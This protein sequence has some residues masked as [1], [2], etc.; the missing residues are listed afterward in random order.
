MLKL[1]GKL[2]RVA[3]AAAITLTAVGAVASQASAAAK[4]APT[5]QGIR[6]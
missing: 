5:T 3:L 2:S 4:K 1:S 6:W